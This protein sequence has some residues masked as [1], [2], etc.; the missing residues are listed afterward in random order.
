MSVEDLVT[1]MS[2]NAYQV[3]LGPGGRDITE[4][5]KTQIDELNLPG[6]DFVESYKRYYPNGDF[7]SYVI[8]YAKRKD[9][10][11]EV[12]GII[13]TNNVISGELGI[14]SEF[15]DILKGVNGYISYQKIVM[16]IKFLIQKK[17]K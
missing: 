5:T 9:V 3:E 15:E 8:G 2:S 10:Q 11:T 1:L 6:I 16:V 7:A 17:K 13:T 14:E 4:I 12:N